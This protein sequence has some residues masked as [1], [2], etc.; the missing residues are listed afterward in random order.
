MF[1][2]RPLL[3]LA[4]GKP[5]MARLPGICDQDTKTTVAA[6][7]NEGK[8]AG[9]KVSDHESAWCCHACHREIDAGARMTRAQRRAAWLTAYFRTWEHI[10]AH[11]LVS[12]AGGAHREPM[13]ARMKLKQKFSASTARPE[14]SLPR[15]FA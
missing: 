7:R 1:R 9:I 10:W 12:V 3:D 15:R 11:G 6:H 14:K 2:S 13:P 5:C 8:G 4:H